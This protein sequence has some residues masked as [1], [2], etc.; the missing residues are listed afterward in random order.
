[1]TARIAAL[2]LGLVPA[3]AVFPVGL[4]AQRTRGRPPIMRV[5]PEFGVRGGWDWDAKAATVGGQVRIPMGLGGAL[6][7][8]GDYHVTGDGTQWQVNLDLLT[9]AGPGGLLYV[10]AGA[11]LTHRRLERMGIEDPRGEHTRLGLNVVAG[12]GVPPFLR[13]PVYP[14]AEFRLTAVSKF[15]ASQWLSVGLNVPLR[16]RLPRR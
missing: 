4:E 2:C 1:M 12:V 13:L 11:A 16:R 6:V 7:P 14:Y 9:S 3:L 10:G 15:D 8:S 5:V